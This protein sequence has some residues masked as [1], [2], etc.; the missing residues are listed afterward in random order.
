[1]YKRQIYGNAEKLAKKL[2]TMTDQIDSPNDMKTLADANDRLAITLKVA[3]RHAPKIDITQQVGL[4]INRRV[5]VNPSK[6]K[7]KIGG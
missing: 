3:D 4:A 1:V 5:V 2:N 7:D 6:E